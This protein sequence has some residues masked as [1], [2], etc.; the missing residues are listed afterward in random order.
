MD[1]SP[2]QCPNCKSPYWD[3]ERRNGQTNDVDET[4]RRVDSGRPA[5]VVEYPSGGKRVSGKESVSSRGSSDPESSGDL[6]QD[7]GEVGCPY[8]EYVPDTGD[9][10]GCGLPVHSGKV[11][12]GAWHK[13]G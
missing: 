6:E 5:G 9:T 13:V 8:I 1:A 4:G 11:R 10:M 2:V 7:A 3:R 12:H